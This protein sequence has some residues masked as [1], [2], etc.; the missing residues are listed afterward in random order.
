M[1]QQGVIEYIQRLL[2]QG[3][4][5]GTIRSTL[6]NA[7]YSPSDVR[8]AM[9]VATGQ[10]KTRHIPTKLLVIIFISLVVISGVVL[11]VLKLMQPPLE[12]LSMSVSLFSSVVQPGSDVTATVSVI[13]PAGR[14]TEGLIDFTVSGP[15]G[16]VASRTEEFTVTDQTSVPVSIGIPDGAV[17]GEYLLKARLSHVTGSKEDSKTFE[18]VKEAERAAPVAALEEEAE[19]V[20][21]QEQLTCPG[22]CDDLDFCTSDVCVQGQ[23]RHSPITPCCGNGAC[24]QGEDESSCRVDCG[25]RR[26]LPSDVT[27]KAQE[28]AVTNLNAAVGECESLAQQKLA[29]TCLQQISKAAESKEPCTK[30]AGDDVRD[31]CYIRFAYDDDFTVCEEISNKYMRNSCVQ[32]KKV[33]AFQQQG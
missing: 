5:R 31:A 26:E 13:N 10:K 21:R 19:V 32:L 8:Q 33:K 28:L 7:G 27:S 15:G 4:D 14:E 30:I 24:E 25:P 1:V 2:R 11:L 29:D 23:C 12:P 18:V 20:A 3:Y 9:Q 6:I 16:R 17:A 22:G